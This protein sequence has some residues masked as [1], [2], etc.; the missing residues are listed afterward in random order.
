MLDKGMPD[1]V[2][3]QPFA[4]KRPGFINFKELLP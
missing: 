4:L 3:L 2:Y 1:I